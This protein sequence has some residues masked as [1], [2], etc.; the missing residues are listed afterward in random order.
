ME[1][2]CSF[3]GCYRT[4]HKSST[5]CKEHMNLKGRERYHIAKQ[6]EEQSRVLHRYD[7][8]LDDGKKGAIFLPQELSDE[9]CSRISRVVE[10]YAGFLTKRGADLSKRGGKSAR[11]NSPKSKTSQSA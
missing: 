9:D 11:K 8:P 2:H 3:K 1:K 4:R 6:K 7:F 10:M 5:Y